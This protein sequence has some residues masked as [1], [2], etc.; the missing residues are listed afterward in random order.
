MKKF[1]AD[2][3]IDFADRD[4]IL[5]L[6]QHVP[7]A[8]DRNGE[9]VKHNSG[10]YA[11]PMPADPFTGIANIDFNAAE[12]LGYIKLDFLNVHVYNLIKDQLH[13]DQLMATDPMWDMLKHK[14]FVEQVIHIGNH[15]T[16]LERMPEPVDSI[17]RMAMLLAIIRPSKRHLVGLPWKEV[18]KTVWEIP[19]NGGYFFKKS[20]S[21][22]YSHLVALHMNLLTQLPN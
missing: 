7:A 8:M 21:V 10:I 12:E 5:K 4:V 17:S 19:T 1:S 11:N 16:L 3:D 20:H 22:S 18:A 9:W 13:Y 6:I 2:I 15:F 14:E